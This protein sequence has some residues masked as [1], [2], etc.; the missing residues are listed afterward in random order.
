MAFR[1]LERTEWKTLFDDFSRRLAREHRTDYAEIRVFSREE[2]AQPETSW[3][4]LVGITYDPRSDALEI[5]VENMDHL[6]YHP[7]KIFIDVLDG[8]VL[9]SLVVVRADGIREVIE[10]R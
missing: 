9:S 2:G 4:P 7:K 6:V 10:L 1:Q 5:L 3:L 8:G